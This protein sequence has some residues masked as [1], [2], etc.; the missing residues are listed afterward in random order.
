M[1][2]RFASCETLQAVSWL[3]INEGRYA[4][5][6]S[7]NTAI[8]NENDPEEKPPEPP[9]FADAVRAAIEK[10]GE[11]QLS[12]RA[13][14]QIRKHLGVLTRVRWKADRSNGVKVDHSKAR[15]HCK[16]V[17]ERTEV[18]RKLLAGSDGAE[19]IEQSYDFTSRQIAIG[20]GHGSDPSVD[21]A[22]LAIATELA[23]PEDVS[24][25][26]G[27]FGTA[28][29]GRLRLCHNAEALYFIRDTL[30]LLEIASL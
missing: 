3:L 27:I 1:I 11:V 12:S 22:V 18:L 29:S 14:S 7:G 24:A 26:G 2:P 17:A 8:E 5:S 30:K 9:T 23:L 13:R 20:P 25:Y 28:A 21:A 16:R 4:Q 10:A 19:L 15:A 6:G